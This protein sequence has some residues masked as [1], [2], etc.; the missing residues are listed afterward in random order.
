MQIKELK[1]F[2]PWLANFHHFQSQESIQFPGL[3]DQLSK[4]DIS[5]H[6]VIVSFHSTVSLSLLHAIVG[7]SL[8]LQL[9]L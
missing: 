7:I 5:T 2:S 9:V 1:E 4:P 8:T 6:P 3:F